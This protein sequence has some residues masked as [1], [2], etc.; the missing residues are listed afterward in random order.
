MHLDI[1]LTDHVVIGQ[2]T[3]SKITTRETE[4]EKKEAQMRKII[5]TIAFLATVIFAA[6]ALALDSMGHSGKSLT[7]S[8]RSIKN[9]A[10]AV[11]HGS[12][13]GAKLTSGVIAI[14]L[15][16][17][18]TVS[19]ASGRISNQVGDELWNAASGKS[20]ELTDQNF[21]KAGLPPHKAIQD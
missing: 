4:Y 17:M 18:G 2:R 16:V 6:N 9:S 14:P 15:K 21:I 7:H 8:G 5:A 11:G 12:M 13:A 3:D 10:Q 20:F 19:A 1:L